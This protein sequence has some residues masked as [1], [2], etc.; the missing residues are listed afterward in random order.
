MDGRPGRHG[1]LCRSGVLS[2]AHVSSSD[3]AGFPA[4]DAGESYPV[5]LFLLNWAASLVT[6]GVAHVLIEDG[7]RG[8]LTP[9]IF[10][11]L[12]PTST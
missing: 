1:I 9:L 6:T 8:K 5:G 3:P 10:P 2:L 12:N 11:L 7:R 4:G